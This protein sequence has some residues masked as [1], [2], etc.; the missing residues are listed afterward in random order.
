[1]IVMALQQHLGDAGS[2]SEVAVD[3]EWRM[4]TEQVGVGAG[5]MAAVVLNGRLQQ[6][7]QEMI[8]VVAVA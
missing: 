8:C 7:F 1:M 3:L 6:L 4:G 5:T 2:A